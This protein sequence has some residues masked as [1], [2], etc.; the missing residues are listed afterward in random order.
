VTARVAEEKDLKVPFV[1]RI[2]VLGVNSKPV[3]HITL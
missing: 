1:F 2:Q 3:P